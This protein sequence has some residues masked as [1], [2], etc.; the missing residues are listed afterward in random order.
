MFKNSGWMD[1]SPQLLFHC[2]GAYG[3]RVVPETI[4]RNVRDFRCCGELRRS[5][6]ARQRAFAL[7][8]HSKVAAWPYRQ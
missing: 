5:G 2:A 6:G 8:C 4:S 3:A 1:V 7:T